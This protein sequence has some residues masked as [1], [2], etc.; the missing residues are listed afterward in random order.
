MAEKWTQHDCVRETTSNTLFPCYYRY[1]PVE[2]DPTLSV[3][4]DRLSGEWIES[5]TKEKDLG[6]SVNEKLSFNAMNAL[7]QSNVRLQ[8]KRPPYPSLY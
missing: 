7:L 6:M 1:I 2:N 8:P 5:S 3:T 4:C